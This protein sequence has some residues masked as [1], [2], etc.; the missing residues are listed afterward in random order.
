MKY[1]LL[2]DIEE[3]EKIIISPSFICLCNQQLLSISYFSNAILRPGW[4]SYKETKVTVAVSMVHSSYKHFA[5]RISFDP[6][7]YSKT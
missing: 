6:Y 4:M 2:I 1:I 3:S 5:N 7:S